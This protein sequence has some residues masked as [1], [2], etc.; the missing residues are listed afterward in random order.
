M[1]SALIYHN[2]FCFFHT[3]CCMLALKLGVPFVV[4]MYIVLTD[5]SSAPYI[6]ISMSF[7]SRL[8]MGVASS[9]AEPSERGDV[10]NISDPTLT[11][12]DRL[13]ILDMSFREDLV[14]SSCIGFMQL[15]VILIG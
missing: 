15:I 2:M 3:L 5:Y 6:H 14:D 4:Y 12:S 13:S 9:S 7:I 11:I 10:E 1:L 8:I